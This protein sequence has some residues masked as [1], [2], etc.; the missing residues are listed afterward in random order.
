MRLVQ[1]HRIIFYVKTCSYTV[2]NAKIKILEGTVSF[3]ANRKKIIDNTPT[4]SNANAFATYFS[5]VYNIDMNPI[6]S[7]SLPLPSSEKMGKIIITEVGNANLI[8]SLDIWKA[9]DPNNIS[10]Y[11]LK[12]FGREIKDF[13]LCLHTFNASLFRPCIRSGRLVNS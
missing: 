8:N 5:S 1:R 7:L 10:P 9:H 3:T 13:I 12:A 2:S 6:P 11:C 4:E